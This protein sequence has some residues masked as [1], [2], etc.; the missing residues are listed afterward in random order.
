VRGPTAPASV[1]RTPASRQSGHVSATCRLVL[2]GSLHVVDGSTLVRPRPRAHARTGS[3]RRRLAAT[4]LK[5]LEGNVRSLRLLGRREAYRSRRGEQADSANRRRRHMCPPNRHEAPRR[6]LCAEASKD[7]HPALTHIVA[8]LLLLR[9]GSVH[10][11]RRWC[12]SRRRLNAP[13]WS[14]RHRADGLSDIRHRV[15]VQRAADTIDV[16]RG[17]GVLRTPRRRRASSARSRVDGEWGRRCSDARSGTGCRRRDDRRERQRSAVL[18]AGC[19]RRGDRRGRQRSV[20]LSAGS[21]RCGGRIGLRAG[22]RRCGLRRERK[23]RIGLSAGC[24]R[25]GGRTERRRSIGASAGCR[26]R[27]DSVGRRVLNVP[28]ATRVR[29]VGRGGCA[30][31]PV[32]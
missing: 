1:P 26:R 14:R 16:R 5:A 30:G 19:R 21:R 3:D 18:S 27:S 6:R 24:R 31:R 25:C 32:R 9:Y 8:V 2:D 22:C 12:T 29:D 23:R 28:V 15:G 17:S 20:E 13:E 4:R 11:T 10:S 7:V